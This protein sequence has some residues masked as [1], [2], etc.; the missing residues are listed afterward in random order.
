MNLYEDTDLIAEVE[1]AVDQAFK[2]DGPLRREAMERVREA[3]SERYP[4]LL[5]G[6]RL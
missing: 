1:E 5:Q 2:A 3:L 6:F 4:E